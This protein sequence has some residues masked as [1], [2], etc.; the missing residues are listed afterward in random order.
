MLPTILPVSNA[1]RRV[2]V[3]WR[4]ISDRGHEVVRS[5]Q[6]ATTKAETNV[7]DKPEA[8][9]TVFS[10]TQ[11]NNGPHGEDEC[12]TSPPV[13]NTCCLNTGSGVGLGEDRETATT[14]ATF[15]AEKFRAIQKS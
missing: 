6:L 14:A 15:L 1:N 8:Q 3:T 12:S 4:S 9:V 11:H 13:A 7:L 5:Q 10:V 2:H